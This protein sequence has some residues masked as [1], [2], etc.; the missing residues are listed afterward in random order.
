MKAALILLMLFIS[1]W[2]APWIS[3]S[4]AIPVGHIR[5]AWYENDE[6]DDDDNVHA[7]HDDNHDHGD[8]HHHHHHP[9]HNFHH[10]L[11][12]AHFSKVKPVNVLIKR[13]PSPFLDVTKPFL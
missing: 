2:A 9:C 10:H 1:N 13:G 5:S 4:E 6:N 3:S 12:S 11:S 8:K 7:H